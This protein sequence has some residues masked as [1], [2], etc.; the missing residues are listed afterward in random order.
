MARA[1]VDPVPPSATHDAVRWRRT[2]AAQRYEGGVALVAGPAAMGGTPTP[3]QQA[4]S[5]P[6]SCSSREAGMLHVGEAVRRSRRR[7]RQDPEL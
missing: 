3:R 4:S 5:A 2:R 7:A 6:T 1:C